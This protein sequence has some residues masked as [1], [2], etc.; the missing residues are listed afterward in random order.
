MG[1]IEK[2][3]VVNTLILMIMKKKFPSKRYW[4]ILT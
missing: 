4:K 2:W 3:R 1:I